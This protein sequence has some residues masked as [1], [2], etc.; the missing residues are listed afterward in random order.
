MLF[1]TKEE[2]IEAATEQ[3]HDSGPNEAP[4]RQL[5]LNVYPYE[6]SIVIGEHAYSTPREDGH[7]W[8][9]YEKVELA[10]FG[11]CGNSDNMSMLGSSNIYKLFGEDAAQHCEGWSLDLEQE[12]ESFATFESCAVMPY[13]S[14]DDVLKVVNTVKQY[15]PE[16]KDL[17]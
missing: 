16:V 8:E 17:V 5:K 6:I 3:V 13:I 2:I 11:P 10:I 1:N 14:W 9:D 15:T 4:R 7:P 12:N